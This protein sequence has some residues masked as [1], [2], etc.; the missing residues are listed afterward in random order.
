M[1]E[2]EVDML[3][4]EQAVHDAL[5]IGSGTMISRDV[6]RL[7]CDYWRDVDGDTWMAGD[8]V[9]RRVRRHTF[10]HV[11]W[12]VKIVA[13]LCSSIFPPNAGILIRVFVEWSG[14]LF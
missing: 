12:M 9:N 4:R 8:A 11:A 2:R 1:G 3:R 6:E 5:S 14:L 7:I 13:R 10:F